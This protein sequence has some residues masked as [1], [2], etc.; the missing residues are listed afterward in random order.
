MEWAGDILFPGVLGCAL[1]SFH[2]LHITASLPYKWVL[3]KSRYPDRTGWETYIQ[4][5]I[6]KVNGEVGSS[7]VRKR[8]RK[9]CNVRCRYYSH[10]GLDFNGG[11]TFIVF[12][13][14]CFSHF[15]LRTL[16]TYI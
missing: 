5:I 11:R 12:V 10:Q 8:A 16:P 14:V 15:L 6:T 13:F 7:R 3:I 1:F 2:P 9:R 4:V